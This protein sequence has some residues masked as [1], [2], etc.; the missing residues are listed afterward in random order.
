MWDTSHRLGCLFCITHFRLIFHFNYFLSTVGPKTEFCYLDNSTYIILKWRRLEMSHV[1]SFPGYPQCV[2]ILEE[3]HLDLGVGLFLTGFHQKV[4]SWATGTVWVSLH[5]KHPISLLLPL[6]FQAQITQP[7]CLDRSQP[8]SMPLWVVPK[9]P[10]MFFCGFRDW[11]K[12]YL[13]HSLFPLYMCTLFAFFSMDTYNFIFFWI[14]YINI[15]L[16]I[17]ALF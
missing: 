12:D 2:L 3:R 16:T 11:E 4:Q 9:S 17:L 8:L 6:L 10:G 14:K 5:R 15:K 1:L 13:S 7:F